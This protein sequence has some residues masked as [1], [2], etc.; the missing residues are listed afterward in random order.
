MKRSTMPIV[1]CC[2][3][4]TMMPKLANAA[5][6]IQIERTS[7]GAT[8]SWPGSAILQSADQL[9]GPWTDLTGAPAPGPVTVTA[10]G[11]EK[12]Y[13]LRVPAV[14]YLTVDS[15]PN[16]GFPDV[17]LGDFSHA[18]KLELAYVT[19]GA[20]NA[21]VVGRYTD[22]PPGIT[23]REEIPLSAL[24]GATDPSLLVAGDQNGDGL[25]DLVIFERSPGPAGPGSPTQGF[26]LAQRD[27]SPLGSGTVTNY[28]SEV[29][30]NTLQAI[31]ASGGKAFNEAGTKSSMV[32]Y[33]LDPA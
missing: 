14:G 25:T 22:N 12:F 2:C 28:M 24:G 6:S 20:T 9:G 5:L 13:R 10:S 30:D 33:Y 11:R 21:L 3:L 16:L 29:G 7:T 15:G 4:L 31:D 19:R 1:V 18:G 8:L 26:R 27:S 17:A 32:A 23:T